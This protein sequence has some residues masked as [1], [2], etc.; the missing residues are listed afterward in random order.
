MGR[1]PMLRPPASGAP[2]MTTA[3]PEPLLAHKGAAIQPFDF[4]FHP[5]ALLQAELP[6]APHNAHFAG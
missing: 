4:C 5:I 1:T 6:L 3:W 2:S